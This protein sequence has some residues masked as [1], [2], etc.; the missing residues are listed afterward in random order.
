MA[1]FYAS[2]KGS[3]GEATRI[4]TKNSGIQGHIRGWNIGA[5][6]HCSVDK[7]GDDTV[8]IYLTSGSS[9][10]KMSKHIGTFTVDYLD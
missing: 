9:G 2:I 8:D 4:G 7:N 3:R 10:H 6:V 5:K 1:H